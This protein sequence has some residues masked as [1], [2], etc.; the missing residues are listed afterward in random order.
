MKPARV[1]EDEENPRSERSIVR[2]ALDGTC[3]TGGKTKKT[4]R[5]ERSLRGVPLA[6]RRLTAAAEVSSSYSA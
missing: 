3:P 2:V 1:G 4:P 5:S 6:R